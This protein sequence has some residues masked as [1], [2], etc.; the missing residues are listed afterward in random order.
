M[1]NFYDQQGINTNINFVLEF[2]P[3]TNNGEPTIE[4]ILNNE[5]IYGKYPL[6]SFRRIYTRL[7][8]MD[9][10]KLE[11]LMSDKEYD[12]E[13]ETAIII[14]T[15]KID[16]IEI[17]P[18]YNHLIDY[19]NDHNINTKTNYLGYNGKWT[20]DI[21]RPFYQWYHQISGQGWL[22]TP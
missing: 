5:K 17:I 12:A 13:K 19:Q 18:Q 4:I 11:I 16:G 22:L 6:T 21:D 20:L 10:I 2:E 1:K 15:L 7:K 9:S 3:I 14:K 8:L